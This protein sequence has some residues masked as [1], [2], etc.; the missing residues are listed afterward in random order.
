M[1]LHFE[2]CFGA[3][4]TPAGIHAV[5]C[6]RGVH[7]IRMGRYLSD[8]TPSGSAEESIRRAADLLEA[9]GSR[10]RRVSVALAGFGVCHHLLTLPPAPDDVLAPIIVRE[11]RRFYPDLF[12]AGSGEPVIGYAVLDFPDAPADGPAEGSR[13]A[14]I[15]ATAVPSDLL[16]LLHES[17]AERGLVLEHVTILPQVVQRLMGTV[18]DPRQTTATVLLVPGAPL[19]GFF[20]EGKLRLFSTPV[21][22]S[23]G[24]AAF[25]AEAVIEHVQRGALFLRQQ[26]RGA[27]LDR[28]LLSAEPGQRE[29][30]GAQLEERLGVRSERLGASDAPPGALAALGSVLDAAAEAGLN[31]LPASLRPPSAAGR[32]S[33]R[34]AVASATVL[35]AASAWWGWSGV[36]Q[37][38]SAEARVAELA[39]SLDARSAALAAVQPVIRERQGHARRATT[40]MTLEARH[41]RLPE[42]LWAIQSSSADVRV[43][44]LTLETS[45]DRWAGILSGTASASS[46]AAAAEMVD[47]FYRALAR[48]LPGGI[49]DLRQLAYVDFAGGEEARPGD[50]EPVTLAFRLSLSGGGGEGPNP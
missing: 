8:L 40:L 46:S 7:G 35:V 9:A 29:E 21:T 1:R 23:R 2:R 45:G 28:V 22:N 6:Q 32:W 38:D 18:A 5:E 24:P 42:L 27:P 17:L 44:S 36:R 50:S 37:A 20:Y 10:G 15:L 3:V 19:L 11:L 13:P 33:R 43:D 12:A 4:L 30:L 25:E 16:L 39:Q 49:V 14:Q 31:L 48:E 41:R 47:R 26:F 34:L